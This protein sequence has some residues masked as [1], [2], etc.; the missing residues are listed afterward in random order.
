MDYALI[1]D[2]EPAICRAVV[3]ILKK[4]DLGLDDLLTAAGGQ[5]GLEL[6]RQKSVGNNQC[7]LVVSDY[8]MPRMNGGELARALRQEDYQGPIAIF[9]GTNND[10]SQNQSLAG[11]NVTCLNKLN[12]NVLKPY[13]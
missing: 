2:D 7:L 4:C 8:I 13:A 11:L 1:V 3:R 9:S 10:E 12:P 5:A 6:F